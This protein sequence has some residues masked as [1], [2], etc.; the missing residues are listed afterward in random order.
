MVKHAYWMGVAVLALISC[1]EQEDTNAN[2]IARANTIIVQYPETYQDSS[3]ISFFEDS[4]VIDPFRWLEYEYS[5]SVTYWTKSQ[6]SLTRK[7][8]DS[9]PDKWLIE[10]RLRDLWNY[11]RRSLLEKKGAYYYQFMNRGLQ[12]QAV[13]YRSQAIEGPFEQLF[14]PSQLSEDGSVSISAHTFSADGRLMG[15]QLARDGSDWKTIRVLNLRTGQLL[16]DVVEEVK[17]SAI[18]WDKEGFYYSR[19]PSA[20]HYD[21]SAKNEFHQLF[22]HRLGTSQSQDEVIFADRIFPERNVRAVTS[23]DQRFLILQLYENSHGNAIY[24][25]NLSNG[26]PEFTP[27]YSF[28]DE[29]FDFVGGYGNKLLFRT[30]HQADKGRLIQVSTSN[31]GTPYWEEVLPEGNS[32]MDQV[33]LY[34]NKL[35]AHYLKAGKS[36]VIVYSLA[37]EQLYEVD[38][39]P[40]GLGAV[41]QLTG[42]PENNEAFL[43]YSSFNFPERIYRLNLNNGVLEPYFI[44]E[45]DFDPADYEI[46][47]VE[48]DSYDGVPVNM[49]LVHRKGLRLSG[50]NPGLLLVLD[51]ELAPAKLQFNPT[52]LQLMPILLEHNGVC[53]IAQI[54][55]QEGKGRNWRRAGSGKNKQNSF[56]DFQAAAEYLIANKYTSSQKLAIYGQGR[57]GLVIGA[58]L[59]QR[60]DLYRVTVPAHGLLDMLRYQRFAGGW[61]WKDLYGES[62]DEELFSYLFAYSP[63]HNVV[64]ANYPATLVMTAEHDD[65]IVPAHSYKFT[66]ALQALQRKEEAYPPILIQVDEGA[67]PVQRGTVSRAIDAGTQVSSFIL[68]NSDEPI[69]Y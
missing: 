52:G 5:P 21:R 60:P 20:Q 49:S 57:G 56:D 61:L 31:P 63:L 42:N 64:E 50:N 3:E 22:Y 24:F 41:T 53:A 4:K 54:R 32:L 1:A 18:A 10:Q 65:W 12:E 67:G 37:G 27:I 13:F 69:A 19:Y 23:V 35:I 47:Q 59:T 45:V 16:P 40:L 38:L 48:F 25:R 11:E 28:F 55:G 58:C 36:Q 2:N 14:D 44:P 62:A 33:Y 43:G 29:Q 6:Q 8:F 17:H 26:N 34:G 51:E 68:F 39:E 7:Y 15:L 46:K 9:L 30:T 66:A